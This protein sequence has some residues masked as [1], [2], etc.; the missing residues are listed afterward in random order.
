[1]TGYLADALDVVGCDRVIRAKHRPKV[2]D[3]FR[4]AC[5]AFLIEV[6]AEKIDPVG[7]GKVVQDIAVKVT[8]GYAVRGCQDGADA[9]VLTDDAAILEGYAI[10]RDELQIGCAAPDLGC[11]GVRPCKSFPIERREPQKTLPSSERDLLRRIVRS[12]EAMFVV[13]IK[14]DQRPHPVC[15]PRMSGQRPVLRSRQF[16]ATLDLDERNG[17]DCRASDIGGKDDQFHSRRLTTSGSALV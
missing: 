6:V 3:P 4:A 8:N 10:R 14:R 11:H 5:D 16:E 12:E 1:M 7:I 9:E 17:Q 15:Q 13:L 2:T